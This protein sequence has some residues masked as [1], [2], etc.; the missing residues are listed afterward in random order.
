MKGGGG[1]LA[2]TTY[3]LHQFYPTIMRHLGSKLAPIT[4]RHIFFNTIYGNNCEKNCNRISFFTH[5]L[6]YELIYMEIR[7]CLHG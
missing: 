7:I 5:F 1:R 2:L 6:T 3:I 4:F